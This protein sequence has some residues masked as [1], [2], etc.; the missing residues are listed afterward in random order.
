[1]HF[2]SINVGVSLGSSLVQRSAY[3]LA[4]PFKMEMETCGEV[5]AYWNVKERT[6]K[7]C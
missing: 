7:V 2:S 1:M 3:S 4:S 5:N 6:V